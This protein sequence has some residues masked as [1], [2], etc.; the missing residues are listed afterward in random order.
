MTGHPESSLFIENFI[1][2]EKLYLVLE[3]V[4]SVKNCIIRS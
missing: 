2:A 3:I 1:I 4:G